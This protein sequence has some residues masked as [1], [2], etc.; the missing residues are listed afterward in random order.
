MTRI[1]FCLTVM[2]AGAVALGAGCGP[3]YKPLPYLPK[4]DAAPQPLACHDA[5]GHI[6]G[7]KPWIL[8]GACCCTPTKENFQRHMAEGTIDRTMTYE[9]YLA[10][11]RARGI[12]TDLDHRHCGNLCR[13]GPH[14][15]L[16]GHC[17]ATPTPGTWM[18]ERVTYGP[19]T[20]LVAGEE[21]VP[22]REAVPARA[23]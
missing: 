21:N 9:E 19:H 6:R 8:G 16:G 18:Y 1:P 15:L 13:E 20:P 14:V 23:K 2:L 12:V 4:A 7:N 11:Y 17:M 5:I 10:L 22:T 3:S